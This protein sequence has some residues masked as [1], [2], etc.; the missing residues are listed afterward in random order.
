V[1]KHFGTFCL[2]LLISGCSSSGSKPGTNSNGLGLFGQPKTN[3]NNN[4]NNNQN[5]PNKND[6]SQNTASIGN[7]SG[8]GILA[9][10]VMDHYHRRPS[11]AVIQV[12][13]LQAGK[14]APKN[15]V[16]AD[17]QGYFT[18]KGLKTGSNYQ[19]IAKG[20]DGSKVFTGTALVIPP[21]PRVTIFVTEDVGAVNGASPVGGT[22]SDDGVDKARTAEAATQSDSSTNTTSLPMPD[23]IARENTSLGAPNAILSIPPVGGGQG[24]YALPQT[25]NLPTIG[26]IVP[27]SPGKNTSQLPGD[28]FGA[29]Q[30]SGSY[31]PV[32]SCV[33]VG[34]KLENFALYDMNGQVWE[35]K[36]NKTGRMVLMDFWF[37]S[38][39]ACLQAI[40][41]IVDL[42]KR[43]KNFGL[44]VV[45]VAYEKGNID[46]KVAKV[47]PIKARYHMNYTTLFSDAGS[48]PCPVRTQFD[49]TSFPT[50]VLL[51][52]DGQIVWR[53]QKDEGLDQ[54][55]LMELETEIRRG[56]GIRT[57]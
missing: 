56:L 17:A 44:E 36:K 54:R 37:S 11:G 22:L 6:S 14:D 57:R 42:Q 16:S 32:P 29:P 25:P 9:G 13:D 52:E 15:E 45:G 2:I 8:N 19:L 7:V 49:I 34:Q 4:Q 38:C 41:N 27:V 50:L 51:D 35:Y 39:G 5:S 53:S 31:S 47:R 20:K 43:Y 3:P 26:N 12:V 1:L 48:Q 28:T 30:N 23:K 55:Q 21:N 33:L 40:P 46:E 10:Q 18:V 24:G